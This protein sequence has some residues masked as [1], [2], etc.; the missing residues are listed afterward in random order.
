MSQFLFQTKIT[1]KYPITAELVPLSKAFDLVDHSILIKKLSIYG[2]TGTTLDWF[3]SYLN[4]RSQ[5][6]YYHGAESEIMP[7][8]RGVPQGSILGP[9]LFLIFI[10]ALPLS[11]NTGGLDMFAD[12]QTLCVSGNCVDE[13]NFR[14]HEN[15][16]PISSWIS[17][18][19]MAINTTKTK[20]MVVASCPKIRNVI[21]NETA[22]HLLQLAL[23]C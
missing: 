7:V 15:I 20:S 6:V 14:I 23:F 22:I 19:V 11:L 18:N 13:V 1:K 16:V 17:N 4:G 8:T 5:F 3:H 21:S 12:D 9:L 2:I 10:N